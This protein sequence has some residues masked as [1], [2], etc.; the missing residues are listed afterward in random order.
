[1]NFKWW[2][3]VGLLMLAPWVS[4]Q[5]LRW[6]TAGD[7]Q[8]LD[9]HAQ[10]EGLTNSFNAHI[11]ERLTARNAQLRLVPGLAQSWEQLSATH[12]R[13]VLRQGVRFHDGSALTSEDVVFSIERAKMPG[14]A[15][16]QYA[17]AL[18]EVRS[19]GAHTVEFRLQKPNPALLDQLDAV[20][21]M[22]KAWAAKQGLS[23]PTPRQGPTESAALQ[24]ANGTGPY[25][26][27]SRQVDVRNTLTRHTEYWGLVPGN[28]KELIHLPISS[29]ATRMAAL[30]SGEVDL[31]QDVPP[32]YASNLD[33]RSD[34]KLW[35]GPE[36][37][38]IFLG[39]D[40]ASWL[41]K[42]TGLP[43]PWRHL[44][45]RQA[46]AHAIDTEG[47]LNH[48][49]QKMGLPTTCLMPSELACPANMLTFM[50]PSRRPG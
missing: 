1:M 22:N 25:R 41:D 36:N 15:I 47:L 12:W 4:A 33:Q 45:V 27:V 44:Q 17:K 28:V 18:G 6:A 23:A 37:R 14:S 42:T 7:I 16:A 32:Q 8:T 39:F 46:V 10:N 19:V 35:Q 38:V 30:Q 5:T 48:V 34:L 49:L 26:L 50:N 9:P 24:K 2:W 43:N 31:V 29:A 3:C 21:I 40:Q 13:F 11:Y 20:F